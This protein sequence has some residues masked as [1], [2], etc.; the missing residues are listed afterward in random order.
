[1]SCV[2]TITGSKQGKFKG[3]GLTPNDKDSIPVLAYGYDVVSPRD[4]GTGLPT[5]KRQHRPVTFVKAWGAATPQIFQALV[6]NEALTTAVFDFYR[7]D[8][9]GKTFLFERVTLTNASISDQRQYTETA[10]AGALNTLEQVSL[11]FQKITL[12]NNDGK[13]SASDDWSSPVV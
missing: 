3:E 5:G 4:A 12:E 10:A 13:T 8:P 11:T 2:V 7:V 6:T 9:Q 1:M